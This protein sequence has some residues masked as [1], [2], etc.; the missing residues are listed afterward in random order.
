MVS[1][2]AAEIVNSLNIPMLIY[3]YQQEHTCISIKL[4]PVLSHGDNWHID[5]EIPYQD[6]KDNYHINRKRISKE[7][8]PITD[9]LVLEQ[10]VRIWIEELLKG[11]RESS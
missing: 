7:F 5:I 4:Y 2:R 11:V 1:K 9:E 3:E 8:N 10:E 6:P